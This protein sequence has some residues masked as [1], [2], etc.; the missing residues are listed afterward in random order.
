MNDPLELAARSY[1]NFSNYPTIVRNGVIVA[2]VQVDP[3]LLARVNAKEM[4]EWEGFRI[5]FEY[6]DKLLGP[7]PTYKALKR[8]RR[9]LN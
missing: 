7:H 1:S 5:V 2:G 6:C 9:V 3:K 4:V 8:R